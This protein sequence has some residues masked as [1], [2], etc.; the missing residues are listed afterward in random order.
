LLVPPPAES[1]RRFPKDGDSGPRDS[2]VLLFP[3]LANSGIR[4]LPDQ[5]GIEMS[6]IKIAQTNKGRSRTEAGVL[7]DCR[8]VVDLCGVAKRGEK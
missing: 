4:D 3:I 7:R 8:G 1:E 2:F 6:G 5:Q